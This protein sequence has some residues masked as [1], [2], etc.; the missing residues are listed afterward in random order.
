MYFKANLSVML[1]FS[2]AM[3][4]RTGAAVRSGGTSR[5]WTSV[6]S[7]AWET[8]KGFLKVVDHVGET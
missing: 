8:R 5:D 3:T 2:L 6:L 7:L 4:L 1:S